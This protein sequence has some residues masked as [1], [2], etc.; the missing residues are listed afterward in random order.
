MYPR[1]WMN[2]VNAVKGN[3]VKSVERFLQ[4]GVPVNFNDGILLRTAAFHGL[5][6]MCR[7][8]IH[9]GADP[10]VLYAKAFACAFKS[11]NSETIE[12]FVKQALIHKDKVELIPEL[13]NALKRYSGGLHG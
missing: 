9:Y 7:L 4:D 6:S 2:A 8:L 10:F 12:Y 11:K 5:T 13:Q 1:K 3:R